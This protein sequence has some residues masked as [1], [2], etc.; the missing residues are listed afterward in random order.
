MKTRWILIVALLLVNPASADWWHAIKA[1]ESK[2]Y[3]EALQGFN[4]LIALGNEDAAFNLGAMYFNG[5]G[6]EADKVKALAYFML[7][8]ELGRKD[9]AEVLERLLLQADAAELVKTELTLAELQQ[10][11]AIW[12]KGPNDYS[13]RSDSPAP[14]KRRNPD[15]PVEAAKSG[16]F[17]YV[18]LRF[19]IDERGKV[20]TIDVIDSYPEKTFVRNSIRALRH[21]QYQAT[22]KKHLMSLRLDFSLGDGVNVEAVETL[23]D[24]HQLWQ[25]AK[26]GSPQHQLLLGSLL[27]LVDVQ[28][29][30]SLS[31]D[32]AMP[33][34]D[35]LNLAV[36]RSLSPVAADFEGFLGQALVR[37]AEDGTI[38]EEMSAN[39]LPQSKISS[40]LG[41]KLSGKLETDVYRLSLPAD[42]R[43][44]TVFVRP[45][46]QVPVSL[47]AYYWWERAAKNGS[48]EAQRIMAAYDHRWEQYLLGQQDAEVM[49]WTGSRLLL[50]G[51]REAGLALL[52]AA[53][54]KQY[55]P[56]IGLKKQL[57]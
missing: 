2:A 21:W 34:D 1:Y 41:L 4:Q 23:I 56:A 37:V 51:Q 54:A 27:R 3:P 13:E 50:E 31:F 39:F 49:A 35:K 19:L 17:G 10:T 5:E 25:G 18:S 38:I 40:L 53:I 55:E 45:S 28:S 6:V 15:F 47:S 16:L 42:L 22:G 8:A 32:K 12:P 57:M 44:K 24:K 36:F 7:A 26:L 29:K 14:V 46:F 20:Q 30:S 11:V 43:S 48:K 33:F 52:D 9:A